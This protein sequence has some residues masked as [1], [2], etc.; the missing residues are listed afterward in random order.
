[1]HL[2][3]SFCWRLVSIN[4]TNLNLL[5][6][7]FAELV[8]TNISSSTP[9]SSRLCRLA[10]A[11][12]GDGS[13]KGQGGESIRVTDYVRAL[14]TLGSVHKPPEGSAA[15]SCATRGALA[16]TASRFP[17]A[18]L[19]KQGIQYISIG[20]NAIKVKLTD[21]HKTK[22]RSSQIPSSLRTVRSIYAAVSGR[23]G[24][25]VG[26]GVVPLEWSLLDGSHNIVLDGVV[27]SI[28]DHGMQDSIS[29]WYGSENV[30]DRWLL[31][32]LG[33]IGIEAN[34]NGKKEMRRQHPPS[35]TTTLRRVIM[36]LLQQYQYS[37]G[38]H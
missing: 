11:C 27:H 31:D 33:K 21:V 5:H 13:W 26:D 10:R 25:L 36:S 35:A 30:V 24:Q 18:F 20:G 7:I 29:R 22:K 34:A 16:F 17:G 38:L 15:S 9:T 37:W 32:A 8:F 14:I 12:L 19:A 28:H 3:L 23:S 4:T 6:A 1:M 2:T